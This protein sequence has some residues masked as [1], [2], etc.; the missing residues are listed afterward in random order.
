M[1]QQNGSKYLFRKEIAF[2]TTEGESDIMC[3]KSPQFYPNL[4]DPMD[5]SPP[6]SS[7]HGI[8]QVRILEWVATSSLGNLPNPGIEPMSLMSPVLAGGF[9][10]SSTTWEAILH[11]N[12]P[13][14]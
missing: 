8:F 3:A 12:S 9:F 10:T 13:F 6:D 5:C 11:S 2:W 1:F 7:V 4:C 14:S